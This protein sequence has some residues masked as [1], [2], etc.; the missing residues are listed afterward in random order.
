[1][2]SHP[3]LS[4]LNKQQV[5]A[6]YENS[7]NI[8]RMRLKEVHRKTWMKTTSPPGKYYGNLFTQSSCYLRKTLAQH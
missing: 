1:V 8:E 3:A 5:L 6:K 2:S 7:G 4:K